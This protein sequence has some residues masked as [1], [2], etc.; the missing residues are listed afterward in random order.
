MT[1]VVWWALA[2]PSMLRDY[3]GR[4]L[5]VNSTAR[6]IV[7]I[8]YLFAYVLLVVLFELLPEAASKV[9]HAI[10]LSP[11]LANMFEGKSPLLSIIVLGAML[12]IPFVKE[13][14]RS[15][16]VWLH[17]ARHLHADSVDLAKQIINGEFEPSLDEQRLNLETAERYGLLVLDDRIDGLDR[18]PTAKNWRKVAALLRLLRDWNSNDG[19]VLSKTDMDLLEEIESKHER[20]SSLAA[21]FIK[22]IEHARRGGEAAEAVTEIVR[23]LSAAPQIDNDSV[24]QVAAKV[25]S[26]LPAA[27][28]AGQKPL[29][30]TA[31]QLRAN[32]AEIDGYFEYEYRELLQQTADLA[33]RSVMLSGEEAA[34]RLE[35]LKGVG[36]EGL[37][38][39]DRINIDRISWMFLLVFGS[40]FLTL[41]LGMGATMTQ[42]QAEG[43]ARF[44]FAMAI[45]ALVGAVVGSRRRLARALHTPW[46]NYFTA[47]GVAGAMFIGIQACYILLRSLFPTEGELQPLVRS[48]PWAFLP[49]AV[50]L[51]ICRLARVE[52]WFVPVQV[53]P[54]AG[55]L[56][57]TIDGLMVSAGLLAGYYM[58]VG[59]L[60][61]FGMPMPPSLAVKLTQQHI[62]PIPIFAPLQVFGFIIGFAIVADVRRAAQASV[63]ERVTRREA[64]RRRESLPAGAQGAPA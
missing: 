9:S 49:A 27:T 31:D 33:A 14:E 15:M 46:G 25:K 19:R 5:P 26:I 17:S 41:L 21:T 48:L 3:D 8:L 2:R 52:G 60:M 54:I 1:F 28:E 23:V 44:S 30:L 50:T 22:M 43:T 12:Q 61:L 38:R 47:A 53:K 24:S 36:F 6:S 18:L 34:E 32:M 57:R 16:V 42:Q 10:S 64:K 55:L 45:A 56:A 62:L 37:G 58:A 29:R 35:T 51:A 11:Q 59:T 40:G 20:K 7:I 13:A 4:K 39:I 63:V